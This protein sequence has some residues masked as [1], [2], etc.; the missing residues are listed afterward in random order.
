[1]RVLITGASSGIGESFAKR[2]SDAHE[3][4]ASNNNSN[5]MQ[6]DLYNNAIGLALARENPY[7]VWHSTFK[8]K[9]REAVRNGRC[10]IIVN[11]NLT[12]SN[13]N[14]EK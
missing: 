6:M 10:R 11:G 8:S 14:N 1:M 7:T 13:S 5:E 12:N 4:G 2:W 3:Y 9:T